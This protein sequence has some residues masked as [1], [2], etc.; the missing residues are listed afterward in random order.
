MPRL[1][2]ALPLP[3]D[4][5]E[6]LARLIFIFKQKSKQVKWIPARNIHLTAKFLGDTDNKLI[7]RITQEIDAVARISSTIDIQL[8]RVGA[9]PNLRRPRIIW[10]G[11][12]QAT[13]AVSQIAG[14]IDRAMMTLHFEKESRPFKAH[15]TLGRVRQGHAIDQLA[16]LLE[17]YQLEPISLHLD[18]LTLFKS[19]LTPQ[20]AVYERLHETKLGSE[21]RFE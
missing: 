4:V 17:T 16:T 7:D 1:F 8:D 15:L 5:E 18:R 12:S 20:G 19:T 10:V 11:S 6:Q 14:Q 13:E 3:G 9:F 2:I 21:L